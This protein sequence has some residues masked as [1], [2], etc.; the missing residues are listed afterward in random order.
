MRKPIL[1]TCLLILLM[2]FASTM[3]VYSTNV[4]ASHG[5]VG[6][7]DLQRMEFHGKV[8]FLLFVDPT[9]VSVQPGGRGEYWIRVEALTPPEGK[10]DHAIG[11]I[12]LT[13]KGLPKHAVGVFSQSM[14]IPTFETKLV[15]VTDPQVNPGVYELKI[16]AY[17]QRKGT[18]VTIRAALTIQG[19][20]ETVTT[21]TSTG[22]TTVTSTT[23]TAITTTSTIMPGILNIAF[24]T[25]KLRYAMGEAVLL[26]GVVSDEAQ[27]AVSN[28]EL[29]IQVNDPAGSPYHIAQTTT[30]S[31][32]FFNDTFTLK[33][34]AVNGT[35][36]VYVSAS[37]N[38]LWGAAQS[39]FVVGE[40]QT[41]AISIL[42]LNI[43]TTSQDGVINPGDEV[44]ASILVS[45]Q[46]IPLEGGM[47]WLEV[48]DPRSVPVYLT[49]LSTKIDQGEPI[50]VEFHIY[51]QGNALEGVYTANAY[52]SNGYISQGGV[53]LDKEQAKFIVEAL[54][55]TTTTTTSQEATNTTSTTTN[56]T[57][58]E[59]TTSTTT[60]TITTTNMTES[61]TITTT[62]VTV[63]T[64]WGNETTTITSTTLTTTPS[65]ETTGLE[66]GFKTMLVNRNVY[67]ST[68]VRLWL[69]T[70]P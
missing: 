22:L 53:F 14:G 15:I 19:Q 10:P 57:E 9:D 7:R 48:D 58:T 41:P 2:G 29:S 17:S 18:S 55:S 59:T 1:K 37:F 62:T 68:F 52:I 54:S 47:V 45:N 35:Y 16:A 21:T 46:G 3:A 4:S 34:D 20:T 50:T 66:E 70:M 61:T 49:M 30:D 6:D 56:A 25:D 38:G 24:S 67:S 27:N 8:G 11:L 5:D 65:G 51:L 23:S 64:T 12:F 28:C 33:D 44:L 39:T 60:T 63:S 42:T 36:I 43:T 40:S 32:G 26:S 31:Q 13:V 69:V